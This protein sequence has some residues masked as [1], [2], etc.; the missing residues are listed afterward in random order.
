M[1][2]ATAFTHGRALYASPWGFDTRPKG[3][4]TVTSPT[5][6][7]TAFGGGLSAGYAEAPFP[8]MPASGR[9]ATV[10]FLYKHLANVTAHRTICAQQ[11]NFWLTVNNSQLVLTNTT[12][13]G[14]LTVGQTY[15]IAL[16]FLPGNKGFIL[17]V[18]GVPS[19][20]SSGQMTDSIA[21]NFTIRRFAPGN[22]SYDLGTTGEIAQMAIFRG[23]RYLSAF[24]PPAA[25]YAGN[26]AN[27]LHLWKFQGSGADTII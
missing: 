6:S 18:N 17:F 26:E 24:T 25:E 9:G 5:Y 13:P 22:A 8:V 1:S 21:N 12:L 27:L 4:L 14:T 11:G 2:M 7:S 16:V 20:L 10:E 19:A 3:D 15:H 23:P